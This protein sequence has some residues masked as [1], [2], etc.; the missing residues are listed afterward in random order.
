MTQD[1]G[2]FGEN[3]L[4]QPGILVDLAGQVAGPSRGLYRGEVH[5]AVL[6]LGDDLLGD[7]DDV[8][9]GKRLARRRDQGGEVGPRLDQG[10]PGQG[11]EL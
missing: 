11:D 2:R 9:V 3:E 10:Q 6:R 1:L 5:G 7:D 8:T 4:D